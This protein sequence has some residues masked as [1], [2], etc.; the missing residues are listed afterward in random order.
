MLNDSVEKYNLEFLNE[1]IKTYKKTLTLKV[2]LEN[3]Q[4]TIF[5]ESLRLV[6]TGDQRPA[7]ILIGADSREYNFGEDIECEVEL[8]TSISVYGDGE[9]YIKNDEDSLVVKKD[10]LVTSSV[11]EI[12]PLDY[13]SGRA[14]I[15]VGDGGS[16]DILEETSVILVSNISADSMETLDQ[17]YEKLAEEGSEKKLK[18]FG[19]ILTKNL[20]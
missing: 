17:E 10:G 16:S 2:K 13:Y 6:L 11:D 20:V 3:S 8:P 19:V 7:V 5:E 4:E 12:D 14:E 15:Y 1:E 9:F 18:K